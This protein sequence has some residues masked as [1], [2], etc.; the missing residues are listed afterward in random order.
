[1]HFRVSGWLVYPSLLNPIATIQKV[2]AYAKIIK[3][4]TLR[5]SLL[6]AS[7]VTP[8]ISYRD[9]WSADDIGA[10]IIRL[11]KTTTNAAYQTD[12]PQYHAQQT[13][14][15]NKCLRNI[16]SGIYTQRTDFITVDTQRVDNLTPGEAR[17]PFKRYEYSFFQ[18]LELQVLKVGVVRCLNP[19]HRISPRIHYIVVLKFTLCFYCKFVQ[20]IF[21]LLPCRLCD[22]FC[23]CSSVYAENVRY[24]YL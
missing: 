23:R 21:L 16:H 4:L 17:A 20:M 9:R 5:I 6:V 1:M 7:D 13:L 18:V 11:T 12:C 22:K 15:K 8:R 3:M 19:F 24:R 2:Q 14:G 10:K